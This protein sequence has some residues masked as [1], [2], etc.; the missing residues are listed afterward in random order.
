[1]F[2]LQMLASAATPAAAADMTVRVVDAGG[3]PVA[4]V[5]V[6]V[7]PGGPDGAAVPRDA[8][9]RTAILDQRN[10]A[11]EPRVLVVAT[12][13]Q[14]SFPNSDSVS[15]QVYSF[16]AAKK[17]Q[18]PLYKGAPHAPV[19]FDRPGLVVLGCNIHDQM[20]GYVVVTD[21]PYFGKTD[22]A[23]EFRIS[24]MPAGPVRVSIWSPYIADPPAALDRNVQVI[25]GGPAQV[26]MSL[27][28]PLRAEPEPRPGRAA[29]EY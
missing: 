17:F 22:S 26:R 21:A 3:R 8:P 14:V 24:G 20:V 10:L 2:V 5:V 7:R 11:F 19:S 6:T 12:G 15:H 18:L 13:T 16:S 28:R 1:V 9:P 29:W 23:G 4:D 27:T 25:D